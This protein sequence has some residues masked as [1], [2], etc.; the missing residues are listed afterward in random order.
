MLLKKFFRDTY[1]C[2]DH[3]GLSEGELFNSYHDVFIVT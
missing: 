2:V 1:V 3:L